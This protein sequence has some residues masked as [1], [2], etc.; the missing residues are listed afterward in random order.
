VAACPNAAAMLFTAAKVAHLGLLPQGQVERTQ[1]VVAMV[2]QMDA[3]GFGN[4]T[5]HYECMA[6]CPKDISVEFI[7]RMNREYA[8]AVAGGPK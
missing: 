3:E 7:A 2:D 5:N 8:R 4:C 6:A 1:R